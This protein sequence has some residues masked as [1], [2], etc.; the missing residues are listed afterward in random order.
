MAAIPIRVIA[1][2]PA[3][4]IENRNR[5]RRCPRSRVDDDRVLYRLGINDGPLQCLLSS[6]AAARDGVELFDLKVLY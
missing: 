2:Q 3:H 1:D 5:V 6:E 4:D